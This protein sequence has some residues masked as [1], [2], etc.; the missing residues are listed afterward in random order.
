MDTYQNSSGLSTEEYRN[1]A[2]N[3]LSGEWLPLSD[4]ARL[5]DE[6]LRT[7]T[8]NKPPMITDSRPASLGPPVDLSSL[9]YVEEYSHNL[10]C[11]ICH[12]PYVRLL[13]LPCQHVFCSSCF[14]ETGNSHAK[15]ESCPTCRD[16]V[17]AEQLS[18]LP[19][20]VELMLDDLMVKC[21]FSDSG[22]TEQMSRCL[23]QDHIDKYCE[24]AQVTCPYDNCGEKIQRRHL[25]EKRCLHKLITC[26][27]CG[28][29][30]KEIDSSSHYATHDDESIV[31]CSGCATT[32]LGSD[33][34]S[35][36]SSCPRVTMPCIAATYG[37]DYIG[38]RAS[39]DQHHAICPLAKLAP[40]LALQSTRISQQELVLKNLR[41]KNALVETKF[42]KKESFFTSL[43]IPTR[44]T[45]DDQV[46]GVDVPSTGIS[47]LI[48]DMYER[49][50]KDLNLAT[51][52]TDLGRR[53]ETLSDTQ[54]VNH[55]VLRNQ[56]LHTNRHVN[57][58]ERE[59]AR[60]RRELSIYRQ[61]RHIPESI[62]L[63]ALGV[64]ELGSSVAR[65]SED[66]KMINR[67]I[68]D[69]EMSRIDRVRTAAASR[70]RMRSNHHPSLFNS[71]GFPVPSG[72]V[73]LLADR[74]ETH[75]HRPRAALKRLSPFSPTWSL[76][77]P[78]LGRQQ[79]HERSQAQDFADEYT[80]ESRTETGSPATGEPP[81]HT[82]EV[83]EQ[84]PSFSQPRSAA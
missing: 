28:R 22:C 38:K 50:R 45:S 78:G 60:L 52:M 15:R 5:V 53:M 81:Y 35:H 47:S 24:H 39:I 9:K 37:C 76:P 17:P 12:N 56:L 43:S 61:G 51:S 75:S 59:M 57:A 66:A 72:R 83:P 10:K 41:Q 7:S 82:D 67:L 77:W 42:D 3:D 16:R 18:Y 14:L 44:V 70:Q 84:H 49:Q 33:L 6:M 64:S 63:T 21:P 31:L 46:H 20:M 29:S 2:H 11:A 34:R 4:R 54:L 69:F 23:I 27:T 73:N 68:P 32:V 55:Q 25:N 30:Y 65:A 40:F 71:R 8:N 62:G 13:R 26:V 58:V 48:L 19:K 79:V 74:S 80:N 36:E 1:N